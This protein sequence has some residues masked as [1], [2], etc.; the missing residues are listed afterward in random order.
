MRG[1]ATFTLPSISSEVFEWDFL[2]LVPTSITDRMVHGFE[3]NR[4]F[5]LGVAV[6]EDKRENIN[7][8]FDSIRE[9]V[10]RANAMS[11]EE[12]IRLH[13]DDP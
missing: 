6:L 7:L 11:R 3:L 9:R 1:Q 12:F 8:L 13:Q 10:A 4:N 5:L 2:N